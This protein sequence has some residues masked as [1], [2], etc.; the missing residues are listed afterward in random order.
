MEKAKGWIKDPLDIRDFSAGRLI[1]AEV[2]VPSNYFVHPD[3]PV[4]NQ[5]MQPAC[6][7][8]ACAGVK[9]DEEWL[10]SRGNYL[11]DGLWLY[12]ECKKIDGITEI[13]GTYLRVAL[14]VLQQCGMRQVSLPCKKKRPDSDWQLGA[15]YRLENPSD[16]FIKQVIFQHVS[17][18]I[19]SR[20]GESG[21]RVGGGVP[22]PSG[23]E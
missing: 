21:V 23:A 5:G 17:I 1:F 6:V 19:G 13:E 16:G 4:Y 7:G 2:P 15:Y 12:R 9:S 8:Y 20:G 3:T 14:R 22:S 11:F 10:Q 18:A